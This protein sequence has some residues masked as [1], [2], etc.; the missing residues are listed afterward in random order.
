VRRAK[1]FPAFVDSSYLLAR[2][3]IRNFSI[4]YNTESTCMTGLNE[5]YVTTWQGEL[6]TGTLSSV[7]RF[8]YTNF[9]CLQARVKCYIGWV[10]ELILRQDLLV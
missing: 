8:S 4:L 1:R 9:Y 10:E 7:E 6:L 5:E 2:H 3:M